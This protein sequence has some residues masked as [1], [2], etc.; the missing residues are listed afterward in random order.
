MYLFAVEQYAW[1]DRVFKTDSSV[2][3]SRWDLIKL[4]NSHFIILWNQISF[5]ELYQKHKLEIS[6][7]PEIV[8]K[9]FLKEN[10]LDLINF[11]TYTYYTSYNNI[12]PLFIDND[13]TRILLAQVS[14]KKNVEQS[15]IVFPDLWSISNYN[16]DSFELDWYTL[17][18]WQ[19]TEKQKITAFWWIKS[20]KIKNLICTYSQIFQDWVNLKKIIII[21]THKWYYKNQQDPR[22]SVVSV[23]EKMA[24]IYESEIIEYWYRI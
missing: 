13:I 18:H 15:L 4:W 3:L 7:Q 8:Y 17:L 23:V 9:N 16:L 1:F 14:T 2:K 12:I 5:P 6:I 19:S 22:Y 10:T 20:W 24:E 11:L 21:D